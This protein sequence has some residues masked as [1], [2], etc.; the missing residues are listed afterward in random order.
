MNVTVA[1]CTWNRSRFLDAT[2]A[3][4]CKLR[5]PNGIDWEL[6]VVDN[7][8]KDD[9]PAVIESYSGRLPIRR[10][11]EPRQGL[12][13]ARNRARE[14]ARGDLLLL[15]D[16]DVLVDE[17]WLE[18]YVGAA[19]RWPDA[20]YFG[21]VIV[22]SFDAAPPSWALDYAKF[23]AGAWA[24]IDLGPVERK[25]RPMETS[26]A[27]TPFGPN[28]AFRRSA[29]MSLEFRPELGRIGADRVTADET[30]YCLTLASSGIVGVW[31][32]SA[33][34]KHRVSAEQL[35]IDF[36][37]RNLEG[38]G[39]TEVILERKV[40]TGAPRWLYRALVESHL[41]Y[42]WRRATRHPD[43]FRSFMEVSNLRGKWTEYQRR[44][45]SR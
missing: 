9:T 24:A 21:G 38:S 45:P 31:V 26:P 35:S 39:R 10:V 41:K 23:L 8:C 1:L 22:P 36:I 17:G 29:F 30:Q 12:A 37:R 2:L 44:M 43:W 34:L 15:T 28:M 33:R 11:L 14:A 32:P 7:N 6:V 20:G 4:M 25:M 40:G 16:D 18:G 3:E 13:I 42:A 19:E 27:E 5:V